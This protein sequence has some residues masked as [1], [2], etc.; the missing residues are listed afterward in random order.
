ME[1]SLLMFSYVYFATES[2][3]LSALSKKS[4]NVPQIYM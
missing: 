4:I 3:F 1:V 2:T